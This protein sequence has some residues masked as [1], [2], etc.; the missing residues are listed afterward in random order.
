M[1]TAAKIISAIFQPVFMTLFGTLM[2]LH[3]DILL[4]ELTVSSKFA[5]LIVVFLTTTVVPATV[6]SLGMWMGRIHD[7]F[8]SERTERTVPYC[9]ALL[10]YACCILWLYR[11]GLSVLYLAPMIGAAMT[12]LVAMLCNF[13]WEISAHMSGMGGVTGAVFAYSYI[14]CIPL[15]FELSVWILLGG[16]VAWSRITVGAC[17]SG[18]AFCGWLAGFVCVAAVWLLIAL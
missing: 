6:V 1:N 7:A 4:K 12:V 18:Q 8:V 5:I 3:G 13:K 16:M 17:S 14:F 2:L 10:G 9:I 15:L 11:I